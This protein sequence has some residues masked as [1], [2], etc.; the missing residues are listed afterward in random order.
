MSPSLRSPIYYLLFAFIV[1]FVW[2]AMQPAH[3][4]EL[5]TFQLT[6]KDGYITPATLEVPAGKKI[7]LMLKNTGSTPEE[8]ESTQP[9]MEKVLAPGA[10]SFVVIQ[11]LAPGKYTIFGEFHP[12]TAR[13][14]LIAR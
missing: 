3:A 1:L 13:C 12:D 10:S 4:Q 2:D 7:K 8:F 11:P 14:E 5:P 9:R 6:A